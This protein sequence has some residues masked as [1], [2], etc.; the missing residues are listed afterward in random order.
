MGIYTI[1]VPD[2]GEGIA[3]AELVEWNVAIGD[4]VRQ[5]D[6]FA[7]VMTDKAT[8]EIPSS[9]EG[10]VLWLGAEIG[11]T[12]AIGA[13]LIRI[14]ISGEGNSSDNHSDEQSTEPTVQQP[15]EPSHTPTNDPEI[16]I[17]DKSVPANNTLQSTQVQTTANS[18]PIRKEG[19]KPLASPS[20]R[21]RA[22]EVGID[23]R[24]ISGSGN[25]GIIM[26]ADLDHF[27]AGTQ[28]T[29]IA[30]GK[31]PNTSVNEV[32]ITGLRRKIAERMANANSRIPHITIVEEVDVTALEELRSQL[33]G[34]KSDD[35]PKLTILPFLIGAMVKA[36]KEQPSLNA[37]FDDE[38][39]ILREIG[40]AHIGIAAQTKHGLMVPV[41]RHC[42]TLNLWEA[43][44]EI[45]RVTNAA[46][47]GTALR[48]ELSG[49]T[50]T[51]TSLGALGAIVTTPIINHPEVAIVGVNRMAIRPIWDGNEFMPRKMMN[52]SCSFDH[53]VIDGWDAAVFVKRLKTLLET[54][55]MIFMEG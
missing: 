28:T 43:A 12:I 4:I 18:A 54:P 21:L 29:S 17:A 39:E 37:H 20:V 50:I 51:I 16:E 30:S 47:D 45:V 38:A 53:R 31:T 1:K 10:K 33:N 6:V 35:K 3:E 36:L 42:E 8:V 40:A 19:E 24:T 48:E 2:V 13:D 11:D 9:A 7:S 22:K 26:H 52:I 25:V 5:D 44:T 27:F 49:S 23:L 15:I 55:A 41:V 32:K 34:E 14:E 46:K